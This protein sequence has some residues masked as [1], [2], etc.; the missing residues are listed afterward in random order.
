[1]PYQTQLYSYV[2]TGTNAKFTLLCDPK[3]WN[4]NCM[5]VCMYSNITT[6]DLTV[7]L[8]CI[9]IV[10]LANTGSTLFI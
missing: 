9:I 1:M 7:F 4:S 3:D 10:V 8:L 2:Q 6:W 5:H